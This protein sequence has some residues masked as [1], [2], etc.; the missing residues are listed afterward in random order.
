MAIAP[1]RRASGRWG[2]ETSPTGPLPPQLSQARADMA[3]VIPDIV[4]I[5]QLVLAFGCRGDGPLSAV[6]QPARDPEQWRGRGLRLCRRR[7]EQS[8]A[9]GS[10]GSSAPPGGQARQRTGPAA[11][12]HSESIIR[13]R[14]A[15]HSDA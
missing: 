4:A 3:A 15:A 10:S 14:P 2:A 5:H 9:R 8:T 12:A 13:H 7:G 6:G 1:R 11:L